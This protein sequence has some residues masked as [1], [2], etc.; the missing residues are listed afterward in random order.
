MSSDNLEFLT[1]EDATAAYNDL[2]EKHGNLGRAYTEAVDAAKGYAAA[3]Q[4]L[5]SKLNAMKLILSAPD[6]RP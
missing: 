4:A 2:L 3:L 6:P 5:H 1:K